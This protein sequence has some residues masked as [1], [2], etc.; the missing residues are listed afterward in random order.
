M[1][2]LLVLPRRS[3]SASC[4]ALFGRLPL[5]ELLL[6]LDIGPLML[7]AAA[8]CVP[9]VKEKEFCSYFVASNSPK[10]DPACG[11]PGERRTSRPVPV[12]LYSLE[13]KP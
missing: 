8:V 2:L 10:Q 12:P 13:D 7:P 11:C 6:P 3:C 9:C 5:H 4:R 1:I